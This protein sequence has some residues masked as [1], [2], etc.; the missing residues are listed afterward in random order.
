MSRKS[1]HEPPLTYKEMRLKTPSV[2]MQ[3]YNEYKKSMDA[4]VIDYSSKLSKMI[5]KC[6]KLFKNDDDVRPVFDRGI[7]V[8]YIYIEYPINFKL[9]FFI[10]IEN[11][12]YTTDGL[13]AE[14]FDHIK[15]R[16][17]RLDTRD[18][19]EAKDIMNDIDAMAKD[20]R[21][22]P[23]R[24]LLLFDPEIRKE[25]DKDTKLIRSLSNRTLSKKSPSKMGGKAK[26]SRNARKAR[27]TR[28]P[29]KMH[30]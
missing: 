9:V 8:D 5:G 3:R 27:K 15:Y 6:Y 26:K 23:D 19:D 1:V 22:N 28:K 25:I 21:E 2:T 29:R 18:C 16:L 13:F 11:K 30:K 10:P 4:A 14:N 12:M 20:M 17:Q 7:L 24:P